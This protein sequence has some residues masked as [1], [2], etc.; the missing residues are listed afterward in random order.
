[1]LLLM[2][3]A[4]DSLSIQL[5]FDSEIRKVIQGAPPPE[6][7]P[8]GAAARPRRRPRPPGAT[9]GGALRSFVYE[10]GSVTWSL[11]FCMVVVLYCVF[12]FLV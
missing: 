5:P 6:R 7:R 3:T 11:Y 9:K 8:A 10:Y 2:I 12:D 1:M 4:H